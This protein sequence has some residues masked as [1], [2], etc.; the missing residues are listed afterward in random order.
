MQTWH[1]MAL[2]FIELLL[3]FDVWSYEGWVLLAHYRE[4]L[5]RMRALLME[6]GP[7]LEAQAACMDF[8]FRMD[9]LSRTFEDVTREWGLPSWLRLTWATLPVRLLT[10]GCGPSA[11]RL[12]PL[13][14][15]LGATAATGAVCPGGRSG[16]GGGWQARPAG[17]PR[18]RVPL[19]SP[20]RNLEEVCQRDR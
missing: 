15:R 1:T 8:W 17:R 7:S 11:A 20:V 14:P 6:H 13:C 18:R 5:E 16:C 12:L 3:R 10:S 19:G 4:Q 2:H 9:T